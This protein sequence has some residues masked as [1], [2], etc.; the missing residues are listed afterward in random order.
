MS[1]EPL[2]AATST[3]SR[4]AATLA[5]LS[6]GARCWTSAIRIRGS[7]SGLR[8]ASA[9]G[10]R[11]R[12]YARMAA[13]AGRS[14]SPATLIKGYPEMTVSE[15][16]EARTS[17]G[18]DFENPRSWRVERERAGYYLHLKGAMPAA[19]LALALVTI[20]LSPRRR[21]RWFSPIV[22][23][24][25]ATATL[26]V[27]YLVQLLLRELT[28]ATVTPAWIGAWGPPVSFSVL[29]LLVLWRR[30]GEQRGEAEWI[31]ADGS[32]S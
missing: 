32:T 13:D 14:L 3:A 25:L 26:F 11:Q 19:S 8:P 27:Y 6:G 31:P 10:D 16:L 9:F 21:G 15:L 4:P 12:I 18:F 22:G 30:V 2:A 20:A 28:W 7:Y 23:P 24:A 1:W 5:C 29:A 17:G